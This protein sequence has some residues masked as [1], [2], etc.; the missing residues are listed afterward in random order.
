M[1]KLSI[2]LEHGVGVDREARHDVFHRRKLVTLV[3]E[4]QSEGL[5]DLVDYLQA[6]RDARAGAQVE[7]DHGTSVH[8]AT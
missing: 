4:T 1:F 7:L 3:E 8:L 5:A 2:G 6:G